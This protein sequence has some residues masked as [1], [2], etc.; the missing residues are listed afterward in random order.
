MNQTEWAFLLKT[1]H[2]SHWHYSVWSCFLFILLFFLF[3]F[4]LSAEVSRKTPLAEK[5]RSEETR[6]FRSSQSASVMF[7]KTNFTFHM[8]SNVKIISVDTYE[9]QLFS[10]TTTTFYFT[11][12]QTHTKKPIYIYNSYKPSSYLPSATFWENYL[13]MFHLFL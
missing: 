1:L 11:H 4:S 3:H 10:S 7:K 13:W 12:T 6:R 9:F 5:T 2:S 8:I